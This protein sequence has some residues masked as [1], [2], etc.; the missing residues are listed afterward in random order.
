MPRV[1]AGRALAFLW[2][3]DAS[4]AALAAFDGLAL[5]WLERRRPVGY[6]LAAVAILTHAIR[7]HV[8]A[9]YSNVQPANQVESV[10]AG[11]V[12]WAIT[13]ALLWLVAVFYRAARLAEGSSVGMSGR[14][15]EAGASDG[16]SPLI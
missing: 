5:F 7:I 15:D 10:T 13:A 6:Y 12:M 2:T 11:I 16:A 14:A 9:A 1:G 3:V 8:L 4:S